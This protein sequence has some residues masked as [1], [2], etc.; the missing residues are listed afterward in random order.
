METLD[1]LVQ[2]SERRNRSYLRLKK[3]FDEFRSSAIDFFDGKDHREAMP[4]IRAL[5]DE[6]AERLSITYLGRRFFL[7][8]STSLTDS[9]LVGNVVVY[10]KDPQNENVERKLAAISFQTNSLVDHLPPYSDGDPVYLGD[11]TADTIYITLRLLEQAI[12]T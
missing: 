7:K 10:E 1:Q 5:G 6:E 2:L 9:T 12:T 4:W 11:N 3:A 8:F